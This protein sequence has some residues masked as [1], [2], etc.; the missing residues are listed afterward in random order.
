MTDAP[1]RVE[2]AR[3]AVAAVARRR[4]E[5]F[6]HVPVPGL[7]REPPLPDERSALSLLRASS[8]RSQGHWLVQLART[9]ALH[10]VEAG[11]SP[12]AIEFGTCIGV[13]TMYLMIGLHLEGGGRI[14][15]FEGN[16]E[17]VDLARGNAAWLRQAHGID[18]VE[19]DVRLGTFNTVVP[20]YLE[21]SGPV[22]L[23]FIDGHHIEDPT[24]RYHGWVREHAAPQGVIVHDDIDWSAGMRAAWSR[25]VAE[26]QC[27]TVEM[28][29]GGRA[30][31]GV[32]FLGEPERGSPEQV[33]MDGTVE[34]SL[35]RM[36][37]S[38]P[39]RARGD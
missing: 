16:P 22:D 28:T 4:W 11:R 23:A 26:E 29:Q 36:M 31:R 37:A 13:S 3:R 20:P 10:A 15:T 38:L 27:R 18:D 17:L 19:V 30:S 25:I 35:R 24:L 34:R 2:W 14:A 7:G 33:P 12:H 9:S 5:V 21:A 8:S 1:D 6:A 32:L 39:G